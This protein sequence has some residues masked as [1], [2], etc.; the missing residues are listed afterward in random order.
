[1]TRCVKRYKYA[2]DL[3][4]LRDAAEEL[5]AEVGVIAMTLVTMNVKRI[6]DGI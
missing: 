6:R 5:Y 1:V 3:E 4:E 2:P